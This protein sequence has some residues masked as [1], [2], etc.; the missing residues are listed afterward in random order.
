MLARGR[1]SARVQE[2]EDMSTLTR[3]ALAA[4]AAV[5]VWAGTARAD[6][7]KFKGVFETDRC[8][9]DAGQCEAEVTF[10]PAAGGKVAVH[11]FMTLPHRVKIDAIGKPQGSVLEIHA[12]LT[13][14][15]AAGI[16]SGH[17]SRAKTIQAKF[18]LQKQSDWIGFTYELSTGELATG[19]VLGRKKTSLA[20]ADPSV[21]RALAVTL[22]ESVAASAAARKAT[23][24]NPDGGILDDLTGSSLEGHRNDFV[25][26]VKAASAAVGHE[27]AP[28]YLAAAA[29]ELYFSEYLSNLQDDDMD[30][31]NP[32]PNPSWELDSVSLNVD[33]LPKR[34][35]SLRAGGFLPAEYV[36]G[37]DYKLNGKTVVF[38]DLTA[39][40]TAF[41]AVL[42]QG[43]AA[44]IAD[45]KKTWGPSVQ[46]TEDQV[47]Y[48]A[49]LELAAGTAGRTKFMRT[50]PASASGAWSGN[51][52]KSF[53][54]SFEP[55]YVGH[56]VVST[57]RY[58]EKLGV[59]TP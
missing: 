37:K 28:S 4:V 56:L 32:N 2:I 45:A 20:H 19:V 58:L 5:I 14:T 16:V 48:L 9:G 53:E 27:V 59:L 38:K 21:A 15:G 33:A 49:Y 8:V 18:E 26:A 35:P 51:A 6:T 11:L 7:A 24:V 44:A 25:V 55:E 41:A 40:L 47:R 22:E 57:A 12:P 43:R 30:A 13:T 29:E 10:T 54:S 17:S 39:T 34:I 1:R 36:E 52:G 3:P 46:L 23:G 42:A 31:V 50:H